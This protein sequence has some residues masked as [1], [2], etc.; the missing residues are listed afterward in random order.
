MFKMSRLS[1]YNNTKSIKSQFSQRRNRGF[2]IVELLIVIVVIAIL[3][4]IVT[5]A[6]AGIQKRAIHSAVQAALANA[7]TAMK[8]EAVQ[9]GGYT[10]IPSSVVPPAKV[11][12]ALTELSPPQSS[13]TSFCMNGTYMGHDDVAYHTTEGGTPAE[14]LCEGD[15]LVET[16]VG[17]YNYAAGGGEELDYTPVVAGVA[18]A[19]LYGFKVTTNL[20]WT[21]ATLSWDAQ[22]SVARYEIQTRTNSSTSWQYRNKESGGSSCPSYGNTVCS[23]QIASS[24][25]SIT[26]TDITYSVPS[27]AGKIYEYQIR[28]CTGAAQDTCSDWTIAVLNNPVQSGS[29]LP[30]VNGFGVNPSS[31]WNSVILS[32]SET[33]RYAANMSAARYEIQTRTNSSTAWNYRNKEAGGSTCSSYTNSTCSGQI[34]SGTTTFTWTDVTYAVPSA[35]GKMYDYR[36]RNCVDGHAVYCG[37][38][39]EVS[40][41]NPIQGSETVPAV[42]GFAVNPASNWSNITLSWSAAPNYAT[43]MSATRYEIQTRT[44]SSTAWNYRL[45]GAGDGSCPSYSNTACSGQIASGT[46]SITWTD[47]T[48]SLPLAAGKI[49]DYRI[50][51]CVDG[52]VVY[53]GEWREV[54]LSNPVQSDADIPTV[55][56]FT[57]TA[58]PGWSNVTLSWNVTSNYATDMSSTRYE[59]RTKTNS[60]TAWNYRLKTTGGGTCSGPTN[61]A[62]SGQI[63][64]GEASIVWT[65]S[66][67]AVPSAGG[68]KYDYQIRNCVYGHTVYCGEWT[69]RSITR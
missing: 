65:D 33:G 29:D 52:H 37:D 4:T 8:V 50:R 61:T 40:L 44:N 41:N 67:Y 43:K 24:A 69:E 6:Y 3:A 51:N 18:Q 23:G 32:W 38:W 7:A 31:D 36:I 10:S 48:Y 39:R 64:P 59:I 5:V 16:I 20:E 22:P 47:T 13:D 34:P 63:A 54:S 19:E 62:C 46:T 60:N 42:T 56:G 66:T 14:G 45:K 17:E 28:P 12:L 53:C 58:A 30:S 11:G 68:Q 27:A 55:G 2:T 35:A 49:Y 15:V 21:E 1:S 9:A 25:T 57:A 26:W